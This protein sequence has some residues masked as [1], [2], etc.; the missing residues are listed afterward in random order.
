MFN[1]VVFWHRFIYERQHK[2]SDKAISYAA[3]KYNIFW[4]LLRNRISLLR[5]RMSKEDLNV[6]RNGY[7]DGLEYINTEEYKALPKID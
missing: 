5:G 4:Q 1:R 7:H 2:L 3:F 6:A